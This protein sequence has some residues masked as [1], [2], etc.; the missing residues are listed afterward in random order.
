M[1]PTVPGR[2]RRTAHAPGLA[3]GSP[4]ALVSLAWT[5]LR[6]RTTRPRQTPS[7]PTMRHNRRDD[8]S[9]RTPLTILP[10]TPATTLAG[11]PLPQAAAHP[12]AHKVIHKSQA[13]PPVHHR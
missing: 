2:L 12:D 13:D 9:V 7:A 4:G 1:Q 5:L 11:P 6:R 8:K 3:I 10:F